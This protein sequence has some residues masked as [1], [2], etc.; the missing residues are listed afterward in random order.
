MFY[1]V[2]SVYRNHLCYIFLFLLSF[3]LLLFWIQWSDGWRLLINRLFC[4]QY[5][6]VCSK[7]L[8]SLKNRG[9]W[10]PVNI[11]WLDLGNVSQHHV[12]QPKMLLVIWS[13]GI[14]INHGLPCLSWSRSAAWQGCVYLFYS[15]R[16]ILLF[17]L[18]LTT[19]GSPSAP[20][21][22]PACRFFGQDSFLLYY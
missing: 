4:K 15:F 6:D 1:F 22:W 12:A 21:F 11:S 7:N 14:A 8:A 19:G 13:L 17:P 10:I 20:C 2:G 9:I 16:L 18:H 5:D 3:V